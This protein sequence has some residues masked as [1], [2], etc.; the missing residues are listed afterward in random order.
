[1]QN[2]VQLHKAY[3]KHGLIRTVVLQLPIIAEMLT[4]QMILM[5]SSPPIAAAHQD[6]LAAFA[7]ASALKVWVGGEHLRMEVIQEFTSIITSQ[8][9]FLLAWL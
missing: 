3:L 5:E 7:M 6:L 1:M 4:G 2:V 8:E 9:H